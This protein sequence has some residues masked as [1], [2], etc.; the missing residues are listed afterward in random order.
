MWCVLVQGGAVK[1]IKKPKYARGRELLARAEAAPRITRPSDWLPSV[2]MLRLKGYS[3]RGC[4]EWLAENAGIE[5][6]HTHL[7]RISADRE[8]WEPDAEDKE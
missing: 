4:S 8:Q 3:W 7:M 2:D 5:V 6:H 1:K